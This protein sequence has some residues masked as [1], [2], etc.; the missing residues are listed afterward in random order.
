MVDLV[1]LAI[2][3]GNQIS[4]YTEPANW[5]AMTEAVREFRGDF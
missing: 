5:I 4:P 2:G 3:T 1:A